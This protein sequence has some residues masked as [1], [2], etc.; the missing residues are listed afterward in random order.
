[1]MQRQ[2]RSGLTISEA[3]FRAGILDDTH[4]T[5][6]HA[7]GESGRLTEVYGQLASHYTALSN[8]IKK[9]KSRLYLP[10]LTLVIALFAHPL[11]SLVRSEISGF[12]YLQISLG[13]FL[14]IVM[15]VYLLVRLPGILRA[16]GVETSWHRL[17]LRVPVVAN[18]VI[19][20][21]VNEFFFILAMM[22]E[23]GW[24][25]AQALPKAVATIKNSRLREQFVPAL[26]MAHSGASVTKT[27]STVPIINA[28]MLQV[29]N[30]SEQSG[31][32]A[33][34]ILQLVQLNAE[35][36]SLQDDALAQWLPRL[37]YS[38]IAIWLL[39]LF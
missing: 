32:L 1:M 6:I 37:A 13:R 9:L 29:V 10:A 39:T 18:W 36:I 8:R 11:P 20:R 15:G 33:A 28:T 25:F 14:V 27:L 23:G 16:L 22:L 12:H 3:G 30:S 4:K 35:A 19:N 38:I 5:L 24:A 17:Q 31:R 34:G 21:E 26:T 2:L 7:A